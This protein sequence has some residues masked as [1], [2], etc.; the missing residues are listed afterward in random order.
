[1]ALTS[2]SNSVVLMVL[3]CL[4]S[5][6]LTTITTTNT[7]VHH[8]IFSQF[9]ILWIVDQWVCRCVLPFIY[10]QYIYFDKLCEHCV[11]KRCEISCVSGF[12]LWPPVSMVHVYGLW[13]YRNVIL[14]F[15]HLNHIICFHT[16][17]LSYQVFWLLFIWS[18]RSRFQCHVVNC[19]FVFCIG[20]MSSVGW[21]YFFF[22]IK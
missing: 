21:R 11:R 18:S 2:E 14:H 1:M 9:S 15:G 17:R 5:V 16:Y 7:H 12:V 8:F 13:I 3:N 20:Q 10:G 4:A 19:S 22:S 6:V